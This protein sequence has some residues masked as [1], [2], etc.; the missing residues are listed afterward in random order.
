VRI[1]QSN[2]QLNIILKI[3][4]Q[5]NKNNKLIFLK[6]GWNIDLSYGRVTRKHDDVDFHYDVSDYSYWKDWLEKRGFKEEKQDELYSIFRSP[7]GCQIDM[8][9]FNY[10]AKNKL[11]TWNHGGNS[12][13]NDVMEKKRYGGQE[14]SG[15]KL[16][17]EKYL[18][19]KHK[20]YGKRNKEKHDLRLINQLLSKDV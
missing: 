1:K 13:L 19:T 9:G 17:V 15:M 6:G 7:S 4:K 3:F 8:E 20:D 16:E 10:D 11:I 18:K 5:A 14:Y 2:E 12:K